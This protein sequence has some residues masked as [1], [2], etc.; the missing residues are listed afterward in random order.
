MVPTLKIHRC[1][2]PITGVYMIGLA[3]GAQWP[4]HWKSALLGAG[5]ASIGLLYYLWRKDKAFLLP[6]L[7]CFLLG[8]LSIQPWLVAR[9]PETHIYHYADGNWWRIQ[10]RV[11]DTPRRRPNRL[12][13]V[14]Q[15]T[16]L[17]NAHRQ[18][19][20]CG[21]VQVSARGGALPRVGRGDEITLVGRLRPLRN[22]ANP[23]GF[24][25]V[26]YMALRGVRVRT[27]ARKGSLRVL[28]RA[29]LK[30]WQVDVHEWRQALSDR[31]DVALSARDGEAISVLKALVL[32]RRNAISVQLRQ[33]FNRAGVS[34][35]LAI[36]G[37]HIGMVATATFALTRWLLSWIPLMLRYAWTRKGASVISMAA[38][39]YYGLLAGLSASTQRALVMVTV[40]LIG[41]WVGRR[42]DRLNA[43]ALAALIILLVHPPALLSVSFQLSFAAVLAI[44]VGCGTRPLRLPDPKAAGWRRWS[45]R[46]LMFLGVSALAIGGTLPLVLYYFNMT[47]LVGLATNLVVV[48]LVGLVVV[49]TGLLGVSASAISPFVAD[50]CWTLAAAGVQAVIGV[51]RGVA[52]WPGAAVHCVTPSAWEILLYYLCAGVVIYWRKLP[53]PGLLVLVLC[54]LWT[55]DISYWCYQRFG[56]RE[57]S[58]TAMDVGQGTANVLQLPGGYTVIVD[59]G[60]FSDNAVFDVGKRILAPMLWQRKIRSV[61]LV[62]LSHPNSDHMN[63]LLYILRHFNVPEVWSNHQPAPTLGYKCWLQLIEDEGIRHHRFEQLP[64]RQ[65]RQGVVFTL[66]GPPRDF[67][68]RLRSEPWR[69]ENNNSLVLQIR[70][71]QVSFLFGGDIAAPAEGDLLDRHSPDRLQSTVLFVPHHGSRYSSTA[72]FL[73]VVD[74]R[75]AIISCGWQNRFG[76][77]HA[78]VLE[79]LADAGARVWPT[80]HCGAVQV[81]TDGQNY[82]VRPSRA[83]CN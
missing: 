45:N 65:T 66:L 68:Q 58:V 19:A 62:V 43:L 26:R 57:L 9:L 79:R 35:V 47:S 67:M 54:A 22:F 36:S 53:R 81:V 32:G 5:M 56:R 13:F 24:D 33:A 78:A 31:M 8:Y 39:V 23:G 10:G 37:L 2:L 16:A 41:Y 50:I 73:Q 7:F 15:A 59:G 80:S 4:G 28:D 38:V 11:V 75:E 14:I 17:H 21:R 49:P 64:D 27:Y 83:G 76:F 70:W 44:I 3:S 30:P 29:T 51:V 18:Q 48:P 25:Y 46:G 69:D 1:L 20:V 74:P 72:S 61:D 40:V 63:G 12:Q 71:H 52:R 77:P 82:Q 34:H 42:H 60:G 55:T 6:V